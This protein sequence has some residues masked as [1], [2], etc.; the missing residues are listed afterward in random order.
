LKIILIILFLATNCF[1][2]GKYVVPAR[3][4]VLDEFYKLL[5]GEVG[6]VELTGHNDGVHI[7]GYNEAVLGRN[8]CP[9]CAYCTSGPVSLQIKS[10]KN[11][12]LPKSEVPLK[13]TALAITTYNDA[14][15]RGHKVAFIPKFLDHL[16]WNIRGT[17][18]GHFE[19]IVDARNGVIVKTIGFNTSVPIKKFKN[20]TAR[21]GGGNGYKYRSIF[22]SIGRLAVYGIVGYEVKTT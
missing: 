7:V 11:L 5:L 9:K 14:K 10:V 20:Q 3:Q 4:V 21:N 13:I 12:G 6:K 8:V 2:A 18:S 17:S 15:K 16:I 22:D 1:A 19:T